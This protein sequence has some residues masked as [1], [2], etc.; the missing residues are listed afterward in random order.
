[1][2]EARVYVSGYSWGSNMAWRFA[3]EDGADIT[4]LLAISG[5]LPQTEQCDTAPAEVRQVYGLRDTVLDFPYGPGED[6]TYAVKLW[7]DRLGC[8]AGQ[9]AGTWQITEHDV[10][11]RTVWEGCEAGRV[12]LDLH[13]RGHFIPRGWIARQLDEIIGLEASYP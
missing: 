9:E 13:D 2:D 5:T 8:A 3:C 1:V 12:S 10:F 6:T 4:A 7:R 11:S